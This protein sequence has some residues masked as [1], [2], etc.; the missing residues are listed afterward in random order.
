MNRVQ[1]RE[2]QEKLRH[3]ASGKPL[4][5]WQRRREW[6]RNWGEWLSKQREE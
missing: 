5:Q 2:S 3:R 1:I 6:S 4:R